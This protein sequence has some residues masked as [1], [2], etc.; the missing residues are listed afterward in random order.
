M[1]VRVTG[2][3]KQEEFSEGRSYHPVVLTNPPQT[4]GSQEEAKAP[5]IPFSSALLE[6]WQ[7]SC[8][9]TGFDCTT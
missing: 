5:V 7:D 3:D 6:L 9:E 8:R 2:G 1:R 4:S